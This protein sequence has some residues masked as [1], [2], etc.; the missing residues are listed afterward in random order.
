MI[1]IIYYDNMRNIR[2]NISDNN[3][4]LWYISLISE[5]IF[6]IIIILVIYYDNM[7]NQNNIS[8]N[9]DSNL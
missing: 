3:D 5:Q 9:N 8:D 2:T 7:I 6:W 1:R 4:V